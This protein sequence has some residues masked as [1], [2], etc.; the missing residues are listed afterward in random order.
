MV[1]VG[2]KVKGYK[3]I[4]KSFLLDLLFKDLH[5]KGFKPL[6]DSAR[7]LETV[8]FKLEEGVEL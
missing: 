4:G 6:L 2:I 8:F 1:D 7:D 5:S 3:K